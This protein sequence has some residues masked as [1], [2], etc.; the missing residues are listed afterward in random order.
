VVNNALELLDVDI[1]HHKPLGYG[2]MTVFIHTRCRGTGFS[3]GKAC[4]STTD[5]GIW[6]ANHLIFLRQQMG[7]QFL[8]RTIVVDC[9]S[10]ILSKIKEFCKAEGIVIEASPP[11]AH[12][13][14]GG[15]ECSGKTAMLRERCMMIEASLPEYFW[16]FALDYSLTVLNLTPQI[17]RVDQ[18]APFTLLAEAMG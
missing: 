2:G 4:R 17:H 15:A 5:A 1:I 13:V 10:H 8:T 6:L 18:K 9:D 11:H 12:E 3:W 7:D 14:N 16:P